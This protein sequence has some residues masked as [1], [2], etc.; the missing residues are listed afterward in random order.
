M[1]ASF[2]IRYYSYKIFLNHQQ[3]IPF[4]GHESLSYLHHQVKVTG[5]LKQKFLESTCKGV[6]VMDPLGKVKSD[7]K[8][9]KTA[10]SMLAASILSNSYSHLNML[11]WKQ[12]L[13]CHAIP[14]ESDMY[15]LL[16]SIHGGSPRDVG[17]CNTVSVLMLQPVHEMGILNLRGNY[18]N[19][20]N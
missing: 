13:C 1:H 11:L 15:V 14:V 3:D 6:T 9:G 18:S 16:K 8:F 19:R 20:Y 2:E 7:S 4:E 5:S 10:S 17:A 12:P